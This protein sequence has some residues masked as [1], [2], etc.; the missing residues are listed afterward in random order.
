MSKATER[1]LLNTLKKA[2]DKT[3]GADWN[4]KVCEVDNKMGLHCEG[5]YEWVNI[6]IGASIF[7]GENGRYG[8]PVETNIQHAIDKIEEEGYYLEPKNSCVLHLYKI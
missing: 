3:L 6:S 1:K 5:I 7:S 8:S 2:I 4:F